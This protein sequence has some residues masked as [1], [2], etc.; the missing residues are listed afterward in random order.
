VPQRVTD[1]S[2]VRLE[3]TFVTEGT[4]WLTQQVMVPYLRG[5]FLHLVFTTPLADRE[6]TV[7]VF[8][9]VIATLEITRTES[10]QER[11]EAALQRG[12]AL[13]GISAESNEALSARAAAPRY[14]RVIKQGHEIGYLETLEGTTTFRE[15]KGLEAK[16]EGWLFDTDGSIEYLRENM[17][18]A[19]NL[20]I[21]AWE[22]RQET[23]LVPEKLK[24]NMIIQKETG[25][26]EGTRLIVKYPPDPKAP[27]RSNSVIKR[28]TRSFISP[29]W[30]VLMPRVL[31]LDKP[32]LYAFF[33]YDRDRR[34]F[35]LRTVE[36][37]G[38]AKVLVGTT[39]VDTTRLRESE[40]LI[41]PYNEIFVDDHQRIVHVRSGE[42]EM[43]ETDRSYVER[44]YERQIE[45]ARDAFQQMLRAKKAA[46]Q[47][48]SR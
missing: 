32:E 42:I 31:D 44:T 38:S 22:S 27:D 15:E 37:M 34:D 13:L 48:G 12:A 23:L 16:Q 33:H 28:V 7:R 47:R 45:T 14:M 21:A 26:R 39:H 29:I 36:V 40:G 46:R 41:P 35:S 30:Q 24:R 8:D 3:V 4:D 2:G 43:I 5:D 18:V 17:F 20:R 9:R 6:E 10:E 19:D 1:R 25:Y 11:I